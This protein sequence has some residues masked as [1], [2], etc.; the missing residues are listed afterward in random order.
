MKNIFRSLFVL[1]LVIPVEAQTQQ[2]PPP[3][4]EYGW[5]HS[6]ISA[7]TINQVSFTDWAQ[8]GVNALSWNAIAEGKSV[9][10]LETTRW[11]NG[12]RFAFGQTRMGDQGLKKTDD[13]I[14]IVTML[15][16]KLEEFVNPYIA[17]SL[18]TQFAPGYTYNDKNER[19]QVSAF[20]DPAYLIQ[21]VGAAYQSSKQFKT[22][23]GLAL[24]EII[25]SQYTVYADDPKTTEIEKT[26]VSA[27]L[28][29]VT[30]IE[31]QID[32]NVLFTSQLELFSA[33]R[34]LDEVIVRN[35]TSITAKVGKYVTML[36]NLQ[37]INEKQVTPRTQVKQTLGLGVSYTVF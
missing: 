24:R 1:A 27:G 19:T 10:E 14:E 25:T 28:E 31:F 33:F 15:T 8:G 11:F 16:Y 37:L 21:S 17:A 9:D 26:T 30:N 4:P 3:A 18:Q 36:F 13:K 22:R 20:F 5:K 23:F 34:K 35:N 7:I 2:T 12:Y 29:S 32:D 6:L